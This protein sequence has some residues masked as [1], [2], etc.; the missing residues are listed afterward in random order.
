MHGQKTFKL[1]NSVQMSGV[2]H[3]FLCSYGYVAIQIKYS[4][5][6]FGGNLY[7]EMCLHCLLGKSSTFVKPSF[8]VSLQI[9]ICFHVQRT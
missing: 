8:S 2:I 1:T 6:L 3:Y 4:R 9:T 5:N 7:V